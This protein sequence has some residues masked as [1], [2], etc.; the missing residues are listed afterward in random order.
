MQN[1]AQQAS[2]RFARQHGFLFK[3][4][5][6]SFFR[7]LGSCHALYLVVLGKSE[8]EIKQTLYAHFMSICIQ[9]LTGD[10]DR[11]TNKHNEHKTTHY[12]QHRGKQNLTNEDGRREGEISQG[13][14]YARKRAR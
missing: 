10:N 12:K 3:A 9:N 7:H 11:K 1:L 4:R 6:P 13:N 2:Q 14:E 8:H 5:P